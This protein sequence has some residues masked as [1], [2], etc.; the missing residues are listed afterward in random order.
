[1]KDTQQPL[2]TQYQRVTVS[3]KNTT[4]TVPVIGI[5]QRHLPGNLFI[6][7][8]LEGHAPVHITVCAFIMGA[9]PGYTQDKTVSLAGRAE[10]RG[11]VIIKKHGNLLF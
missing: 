3:Q 4:D 8:H 2:R 5:G 9:A 7:Q 11:I 1:M 6:R 10:H